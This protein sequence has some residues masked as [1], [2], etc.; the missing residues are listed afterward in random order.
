MALTI[1]NTFSTGNTALASEVNANFQAVKTEVDLK[2]GN[3]LLTTKGDII[4]ASAAS[5]PA[6]LSVGTNGQTLLADSTATNGVAWGQVAAAG[7]ASNAVTTAKILDANV[8]TAKILDGA[9]TP[10]KLSSYPKLI[11]PHTF[12]VGGPVNVQSGQVDYIL[13]FFV[14]VPSTQ[15][16]KLISARH[17]INSGT[18]ATSKVQVNGSD[19]TGFTGMSV[20]TSS[21]DT[22][23]AD[24]T[25]SNNDVVSLVV[26]AVSGSPQN[27]SVTV[28]FEYTWTG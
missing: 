7:I 9:V 18:S 21:T 24:I 11:I 17:R 5:T 14:K 12:T 8:T 22:D 2:I 26:T 15:T 23:P 6:R 19:A 1:P 25:L 13:P 20:T 28:F 3:T 10:G 4:A 27:M 16:V